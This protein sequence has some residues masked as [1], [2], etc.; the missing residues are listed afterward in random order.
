MADEIQEIEMISVEISKE[1]LT[2]L[3]WVYPSGTVEQRVEFTLENA[4]EEAEQEE[5]VKYPSNKMPCETFK[6]VKMID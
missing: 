3:S 1:V 6:H 5:G 4:I 2:K